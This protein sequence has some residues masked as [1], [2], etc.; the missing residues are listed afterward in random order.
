MSAAAR[1]AT[2]TAAMVCAL[3]AVLA[4]AAVD[5]AELKDG[6]LKQHLSNGARLIV[7]QNDHTAT[8]VM[9]ALVQVTAL[10]EPPGK[11]G[12]RQLTAMMVARG[13]TF[14]G[15]M[16]EAAVRGSMSVAPDYAELVLGAPV[17]SLDECAIA[18]RELLFRPHFTE[19]AFEQERERLVRALLARDEVPASFAVQRLYE[20]IYPGIGSADSSAGDPVEV[21]RIALEDV[22]K[23][24]AA[25]YLP[26]A[27]VIAVSGGVAAERALDAI[28]RSMRGV[29]PGAL[30]EA[31]PVLQPQER[32]L[33]SIDIGGATSAYAVGGRAVSL[34]HDAY[35]AMA[36]GMA[37]LGSGMGSSLYRALRLD[38]SLA[39]TIATELTPAGTAPSGLVLVTTDP[40]H[41]DEVQQIVDAEI[42]QLMTGPVDAAQLQ[43]ARQYLVGR[44]ALRRQRNHEV[45]HYLAVFELL[46]GAQGYRRDG[47]LVGEMA[48][49]TGPQVVDAMQRLFDPAWAVRLQAVNN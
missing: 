48:T 44:H 49:V 12:I 31:P 13:D 24:H 7:D 2:T 8:V 43:R 10:H 37:M 17:E 5:A 28:S 32:R 14:R 39:Y 34:S 46:G 41:L 33:L 26:N 20:Q 47:R 36:V 15:R 3:T 42:E 45:S 16:T 19:Q 27:T 11:R 25:H 9:S 38:R 21:A 23:F 1:H 4:L 40:Q 30:A 29:L 6:P 35:P 18:M 22:R